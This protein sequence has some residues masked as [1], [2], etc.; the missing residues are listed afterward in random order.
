MEIPLC[1]NWQWPMS[2]LSV[3]HIGSV[4]PCR[5]PFLSEAGEFAP[6]DGV[7]VQHPWKHSDVRTGL[8]SRLLVLLQAKEV[9]YSF[10]RACIRVLVMP[11]QRQ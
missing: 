5:I 11:P 7:D 10:C 8:L 9:E 2:A 6:L 3:V 1:E 4:K